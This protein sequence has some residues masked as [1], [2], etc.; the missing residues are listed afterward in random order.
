MVFSFTLFSPNKLLCTYILFLYVFTRRAWILFPCEIVLLIPSLHVYLK[1]IVSKAD[2]T[3]SQLK[4]LS[5]RLALD[6]ATFSSSLVSIIGHSLGIPTLSTGKNGP[7]KEESTQ[8]LKR[9][10]YP[11]ILGHQ[12][13]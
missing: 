7:I 12:K 9:E 10:H 13:S 11:T 1:L 6:P 8:R 4:L 2:N 5:I 3:C